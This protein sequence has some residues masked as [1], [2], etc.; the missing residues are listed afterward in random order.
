MLRHFQRSKTP[1]R[2]VAVLAALASGVVLPPAAPAVRPG[3]NGRVAYLKAGPPGTDYDVVVFFD[4][5]FNKRLTGSHDFLDR[6]TWCDPQTLVGVQRDVGIVVLPLDPE[7]NLGTPFVLYDDPA[8]NL[9]DPACD[10]SGH[11]VAAADQS[12]NSIVTIPVSGR[13]GLTSP[14]AYT[15]L[16]G[17]PR[18]PTWS[19]SGDNIAYEDDAPGV[20]VI[21]VA[22]ASRHFIGSGTVVTPST[23]GFR[24]GPSWREN[25]IYYWL[26]NEPRTTPRTSRGIFSVSLGDLNEFGPYGGTQAERC[27]DPAAL[28]DGDGFLCVGADTFIKRFPGPRTLIDTDARKPDVERRTEYHHEEHHE[29]HHEDHHWKKAC[30]CKA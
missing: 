23:G 24:H 18:E 7:A 2:A 5:R 20:S 4:G 21:E 1:I 16:G 17:V 15:A 12:T 8:N 13:R 28:P 9:R 22:A 11:K 3:A 26:E 27:V 25:K 29:A 19:S 10:P 6:V 30:N 14:V